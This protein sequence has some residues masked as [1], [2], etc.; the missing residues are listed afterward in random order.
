MQVEKTKS[1]T[2]IRNQKGNSM[3]L[4]SGLTE[5]GVHYLD[6]YTYRGYEIK[7]TLDKWEVLSGNAKGL[8]LN[9]QDAED[10]VDFEIDRSL[11]RIR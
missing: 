9:Q 5:A 11:E 1:K 10:M 4:A 8:Y 6:L 2:H 3:T 7:K